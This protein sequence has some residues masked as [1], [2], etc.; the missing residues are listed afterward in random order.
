MQF[1]IH[2]HK[3]SI[4]LVRCYRVR[5]VQF[6]WNIQLS[7]YRV[8]FSRSV[9]WLQKQDRRVEDRRDSAIRSSLAATARR[10][11][12]THVTAHSITAHDGETAFFSS[13]V[14]TSVGPAVTSV[15]AEAKWVLTARRDGIYCHRVL[16]I[17]CD[18][19]GISIARTTR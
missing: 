12:I 3:L 1:E 9:L 13:A 4:N 2:F 11:D 18:L 8:P 19:M 14:F 15:L 5:K 16:R 6:E 10:Y 17:F 7:G